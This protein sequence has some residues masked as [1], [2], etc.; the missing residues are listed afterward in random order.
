MSNYFLKKTAVSK[1]Q[2]LIIAIIIL[3]AIIA[4]VY[5]YSTLQQAPMP[6]ST[7]TPKPTSTPGSP[8][9]IG[10]VL[11]LTGGSARLGE[12]EK[13]A[14]LMAIEEINAKGGI[15]GRKLEVIFED[16][17]GNSEKCLSVVKK[18]IE[19]DKVDILAGVLH[20]GNVIAISEY[21]SSAGIP[22]ISGSSIA[23]RLLYQSDPN[24]FKNFFTL[25]ADYDDVGRFGLKFLKEVVNA[26][27]FAVI[28]ESVTSGIRSMDYLEIFA[29]DNGIKCLGKIDVPWGC[30]D[31]SDAIMKVKELNPDALV[32]Y[33]FSGAEV[34]L[35]RQLYE[36]KL[37]IPYCGIMGFVT[38][39][40]FCETAKE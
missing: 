32:F 37:P 13:Q 30:K 29:A 25:Q 11:P 8:I 24:K 40:A 12:M 1:M 28:R 26:K 4:G 5:Y 23:P 31:F 39:P 34:T 10:Y 36:N 18:L 6:T 27:T 7:P 19:L 16:D 3:A 22:Y 33:V 14:A 35:V 9:K 20:S 21:V 38:D 2:A 15:L 17:E